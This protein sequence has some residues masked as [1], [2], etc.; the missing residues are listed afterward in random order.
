MFFCLWFVSYWSCSN[1]VD[2][3]DFPKSSMRSIIKFSVLPTYNGENVYVEHKG[4]INQKD[5]TITLHLSPNYDLTKIRP[6]ITLS[7]MT[8]VEPA[9]Y[10]PVDFSSL[11]KT[12]CAIA[13]NGKL[14]YYDVICVLDYKYK[15]NT[16]LAF[17][18]PEI[19]DPETGRPLR[20]EYK[21]TWNETIYVDPSV[22]L[23]AIKIGFDVEAKSNFCTFN[24]DTAAYYDFATNANGISF[25]VTA[26]SGGAM[27]YYKV[28]VKHKN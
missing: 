21:G 24:K 19:I 15:G 26:Q 23:S 2:P 12:Y 4:E 27:N 13:E 22:D 20:K 14:A 25:G 18:L 5:K 28:N 11:Q 8:T 6:E 7:P 3:D 10:E 16:I 1:E 9:N 17:Y